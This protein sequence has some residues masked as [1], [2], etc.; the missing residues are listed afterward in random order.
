MAKS[1]YVK[2][3]QRIA[4]NES[5]GSVYD[6]LQAA[7]ATDKSIPA[8]KKQT[9]Y[10]NTLD[11]WIAEASVRAAIERRH[12]RDM[13]DDG[14]V[15]VVQ[16]GS[17]VVK[18]G[19]TTHPVHRLASHA[20][21]A[22]IHNGSVRTSWTSERHH[23]CSET[24]RQLIAFCKKR[25][26]RVFGKEYFRSVDFDVVRD[27]ADVLV[28]RGI[29][30]RA[31]AASAET[32]DLVDASVESMLAG[33]GGDLDANAVEAWLRGTGVADSAQRADGAVPPGTP[34]PSGP[35]TGPSGPTHPTPTGPT[36]PPPPPR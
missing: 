34:A 28:R 8:N 29:Y 1:V 35:P 12:L 25:G 10:L 13:I 17:G 31:Y 33:S 24:E 30:G 22:G 21:Y 18:V 19:K 14:H 6:D 16:F 11:R 26:I 27:L 9:A 3:E 2:L 32:L 36:Q 5:G 20:K 15:Y 4:A 23:G 7:I